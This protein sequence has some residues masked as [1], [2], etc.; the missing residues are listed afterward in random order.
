MRTDPDRAKH[1]GISLLII[2]MDT[3]GIDVRPLK[4]ITGK[5]DF[6]EVFFTDVEV[7]RE[8]LVGRNCTADGRS[9]KACSRTSG[10]DCGSRASPAS[11]RPSRP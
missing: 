1:K 5:A 6:A 8:N 2:D 4:H 9:R 3:P 10:R 11:S 7:P